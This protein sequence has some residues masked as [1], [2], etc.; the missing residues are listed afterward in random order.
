MKRGLP[1]VAKYAS[2]DNPLVGELHPSVSQ[3]SFYRKVFS[4]CVVHPKNP[5]GEKLLY[6]PCFYSPGFHRAAFSHPTTGIFI[7]A[8]SREALQKEEATYALHNAFGKEEVQQKKDE[9][10]FSP[11]LYITVSFVS[12][13]LKT[14]IY[15]FSLTTLHK[16]PPPLFPYPTISNIVI[17]RFIIAKW[18]NNG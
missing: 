3:Y 1:V 10:L 12:Q 8:S 6:A 7:P 11:A 13:Y 18:P 2:A 16:I 4:C 17:I 9:N 14:T 15:S 5:S